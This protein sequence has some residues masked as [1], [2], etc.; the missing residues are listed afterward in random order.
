MRLHA[1]EHEIILL[2]E[3]RIENCRNL[4]SA[5]EHGWQLVTVIDGLAY[6]K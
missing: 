4:N 3:D 2:T 5:G 1:W 6:L